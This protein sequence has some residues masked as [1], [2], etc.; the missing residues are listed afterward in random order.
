MRLAKLLSN[1]NRRAGGLPGVARGGLSR[2]NRQDRNKQ[3]TDNRQN[4][5][6]HFSLH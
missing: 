5:S 6:S 4:S 1:W 2:L 3:H